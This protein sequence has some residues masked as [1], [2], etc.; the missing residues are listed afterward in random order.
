MNDIG[1]PGGPT[2]E[3]AAEREALVNEIPDRPVK[4]SAWTDEEIERERARDAAIVAETKQEEKQGIPIP[5]WLGTAFVPGTI[6]KH[7]GVDAK[8][9]GIDLMPDG[10]WIAILAPQ[11]PAAKPKSRLRAE[12]HR[13]AREVG[14]KKAKKMMR[15]RN[16]PKCA[17]CGIDETYEGKLTALSHKS[18]S[19]HRRLV[20]Q[21]QGDGVEQAPESA[22]ADDATSTEA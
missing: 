15:E 14:K 4:S 16:N 11:E 1:N 7:N 5:E 10:V 21:G 22:P 20:A 13:L 2:P 6:L 3:E 12:Y 18:R 17:Q 19:E 9:M 8:I